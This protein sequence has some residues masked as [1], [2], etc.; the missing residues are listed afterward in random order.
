[1]E[2]YGIRGAGLSWV[3]SYIENRQQFVQI[4]E[5]RST[6]LDI[7]CG[8]PQGSIL[9]P[10]LFILYINDICKV[11]S[12]LNLVV[13]ADDT[14]IFCTGENLNQLLHDVSVDLGKLKLW[15]DCNKLSLNI[16]KTKFIVFGKRSIQPNT[17]VEVLITVIFKKCL[18]IEMGDMHQ[19][20]NLILSNQAFILH[21]KACVFV[22]LG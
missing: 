4:G 8:V 14:N 17:L 2:R 19:E 12:T 22:L 5:H 7:I 16:S 3:K 1:M 9:G 21:L 20:G 15:F 18:M 10:T 6:C 11:S 13:F